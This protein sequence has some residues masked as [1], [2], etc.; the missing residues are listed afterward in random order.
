MTPLGGWLVSRSSRPAPT[1]SPSSNSMEWKG[2]TFLTLSSAPLAPSFQGKALVVT[3]SVVLLGPLD[4]TKLLRV[5]PHL[6]ACAL[7]CTNATLT[8]QHTNTPTGLIRVT[9]VWEHTVR[10][11]S[12]QRAFME[13]LKEP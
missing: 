8:H 7:A 4:A 3:T 12:T 2:S 13:K 9:Y 5:Y 6:A 11:K 10:S 1:P